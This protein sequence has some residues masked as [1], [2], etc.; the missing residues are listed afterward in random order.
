MSVA[1]APVESLASGFPFLNSLCETLILMALSILNVNKSV[2]AVITLTS[3]LDAEPYWFWKY[4]YVA[5]T[6]RSASATSA[7]A[8]NSFAFFFSI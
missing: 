2:V 1:C 3:A 7:I 4:A 8:L 6:T 5:P